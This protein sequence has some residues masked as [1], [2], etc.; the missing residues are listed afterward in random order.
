MV[1]RREGDVERKSEQA[2]LIRKLGAFLGPFEDLVRRPDQFDTQARSRL[3]A[4]SFVERDLLFQAVQRFTHGEPGH[5]YI[6]QSNSFET[7]L[8]GWM[9]TVEKRNDIDSLKAALEK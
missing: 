9:N 3:F 1:E 6:I 4:R 5:R 7:A 2:D 8:I